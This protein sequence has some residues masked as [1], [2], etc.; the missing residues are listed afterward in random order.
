MK[1]SIWFEEIETKII[2][3]NI[4]FFIK[5]IAPFKANHK[6]IFDS[7]KLMIKFFEKTHDVTHGSN[8]F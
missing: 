3:K 1:K 2:W 7:N 5:F 6:F 4:S 8:G